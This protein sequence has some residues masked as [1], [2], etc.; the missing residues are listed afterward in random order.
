MPF[1]QFRLI[2]A[3]CVLAML[4]QGASAQTVEEAQAAAK[5]GD[6]AKAE[7]I[8]TPLAEDD[9]PIALRELARLH[10]SGRATAPDPVK[11]RDLLE[12][13]VDGGLSAAGLDLG[14]VLLEGIG[15]PKDEAAAR[16]AFATAAEADPENVEA[17]FMWG[18]LTLM[19]SKDPEELRN[20]MAEIQLA[21][22][23][24]FGP[25]LALVGDFYMSGTFVGRDPKRAM[26][27]YQ[28]AYANGHQQSAMTVA[29]LFA[30]GDMGE[31][32][33]VAARNW[34]ARAAS[35]GNASAAYAVASLIYMD[36]QSTED[37]LKQAFTFANSAALAWNEDAQM[38]LG[39]MYLDGRAVP[40]D[41]YLA[42]KWLDLAATSAVLDA[43][44]LRAIAAREL[45]PEQSAKA[46]E[47]ARAWF[48]A[49]HA[50]PHTHR[51]LS[52]AEHV[53]K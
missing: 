27:F 23:R 9:D 40:R 31:V 44:Y 15:G 48:Q 7:V 52:G 14:Y 45:G 26:G 30:F 51:L 10:L 35:E 50:T 17:R 42:F 24:K 2:A 21:A 3:S 34:Y 43:H 29:D 41:P 47:E 13:A 28:D 8:L 38:L 33:L 49:N 22:S 5:A 37:D 20:G 53:F 46:R 16:E 32:D 1:P 12:Q 18:K 25:A 36:P 6:F 19:V 39:Q 4:C 11:A